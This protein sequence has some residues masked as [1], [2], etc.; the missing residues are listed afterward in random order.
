MEKDSWWTAPAESEDGHLIMVTGN[1]DVAKFRSNPRFCIRIEVSWNYTGDASGM[2]DTATSELMEQVQEALQ[3]EFRK[4][5]VAIL[6]G[7][8]TGDGKREWVFYSV[9]T[10]IF[11]KKLNQA[12]EPFPLLPITVYCENDPGWE[13]YDEMTQAEIRFD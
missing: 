12:L 7:I 5:P 10:H 13:G 3:T 4:D 6:T 8:F 9:S 2:P 11:G 1:K